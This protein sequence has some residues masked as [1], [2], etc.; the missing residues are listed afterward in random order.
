VFSFQSIASQLDL[1]LLRTLVRRQ[2]A[3][4][5]LLETT[6]AFWKT[7]PHAAAA[8]VCGVKASAADMF[9]QANEWSKTKVNDTGVVADN[10]SNNSELFWFQNGDWKSNLSFIVC[11]LACQGLTQEHVCSHMHPLWFGADSGLATALTNAGAEAVEAA[12]ATDRSL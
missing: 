4:I 3:E 1:G 2:A 11:G 6:D 7:S 10:D 5:A 12:A 9:A 8:L